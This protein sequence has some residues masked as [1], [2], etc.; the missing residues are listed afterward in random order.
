MKRRKNTI[1]SFD[2]AFQGLLYALR[3]QR[4]LRWH[5]L[6]GCSVVL[7][8]FWL[9]LTRLETI[10]VLSAVT[11]VILAELVNTAI[12]TTIDLCTTEYH[13]LAAV[14]KNVAAGAVL[15]T[16]F[17]A[18][19]V[20]YVIFV[21]SLGAYL[22]LVIENVRRSPP[23]LTLAALVLVVMAV[24]GLKILNRQASIMQGGMPSGHTA[25]AFALAAAVIFNAGRNPTIII[26]VSLM[27]LL[28]AESRLET[29]IH[30]IL[31]VLAGAALGVLLT[32]AIFQLLYRLG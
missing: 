29:R 15:L 28:V 18:L 23:Y 16:A 21:P 5:A 20:G 27:A 26:L 7:L 9:R 8:A 25:I 14:A 19:I 22:P 3:T 32:T 30:T 24:V 6:I 10:V 12:E 17:F 1:E 4:H 11:L 31:E 13:P 2:W